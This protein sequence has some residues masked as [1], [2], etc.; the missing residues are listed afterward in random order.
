VLLHSSIVLAKQNKK[1]LNDSLLSI[2]NIASKVGIKELD[3]Y[4][5]VILINERNVDNIQQQQKKRAHNN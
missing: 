2:Y 1:N 4:I 5:S 3:T